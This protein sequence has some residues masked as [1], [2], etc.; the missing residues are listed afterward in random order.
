MSNLPLDSTHE[1]KATDAEPDGQSSQ[2]QQNLTPTR[3]P[4]PVFSYGVSRQKKQPGNLF[5][6]GVQV[7]RGPLPPKSYSPPGPT[8]TSQADTDATKD[9]DA[10]KPTELSTGK[11][12]NHNATTN[13]SSVTTAATAQASTEPESKQLEEVKVPSSPLELVQPAAE[14]VNIN[15]ESSAGIVE[16]SS[17][18]DAVA[19]QEKPNPVFDIG[20]EIVGAESYENEEALAQLLLLEQ[21]RLLDEV[22]KLN[23]TLADD[24][25]SVATIELRVAACDRARGALALRARELVDE[26]AELSVTYSKAVSRLAELLIDRE[27]RL[28]A[29]SAAADS[30]NELREKT[31]ML[32]QH[33]LSA[34]ARM[35]ALQF[36]HSLPSSMLARE[37]ETTR[38]KYESATALLTNWVR[39]ECDRHRQVTELQTK[40]AT[41]EARLHEEIKGTGAVTT[42]EDLTETRQDTPEPSLLREQKDLNADTQM[43]ASSRTSSPELLRTKRLSRDS[44]DSEDQLYYRARLRNQSDSRSRS[45]GRDSLATSEDQSISEAVE[46]L[47]E[48]LR[49]SEGASTNAF[50]TKAE[51]AGQAFVSETLP[52]EGKVVTK[53]MPHELITALEH[54]TH[55]D[56]LGDE[57][58]VEITPEDMVYSKDR[59]SATIIA[60]NSAELVNSIRAQLAEPVSLAQTHSSAI[61]TQQP[62]LSQAHGSPT[63]SETPRSAHELTADLEKLR[64]TLAVVK[65]EHEKA[66]AKVRAEQNKVNSCIITFQALDFYSKSKPLAEKRL[67]ELKTKLL[68]EMKSRLS[69]CIALLEQLS[70]SLAEGFSQ[71]QLLMRCTFKLELLIEVLKQRIGRTESEY[72]EVL[73]L[74]AHTNNLKEE[75]VHWFTTELNAVNARSLKIKQLHAQIAAYATGLS[76]LKKEDDDSARGLMVSPSRVER[77]LKNFSQ[78]ESKTIAAVSTRARQ[79]YKAAEAEALALAE[80]AAKALEAAS[81]TREKAIAARALVTAPSPTDSAAST[82]DFEDIDHGKLAAIRAR[83]LAEAES[84]EAE[85][86]RLQHESDLASEAAAQASLRASS[87]RQAAEEEALAEAAEEAKKEQDATASADAEQISDESSEP[88]HS[89]ED[90]I[91]GIYREHTKKIREKFNRAIRE[92]LHLIQ[93][94]RSG[95]RGTVRRRPISLLG[96]DQ[97]GSTPASPQLGTIELKHSEAFRKFI[98]VLF[99]SSQMN[100]N[101]LLSGLETSP[102]IL[103]TISELQGT[104]SDLPNSLVD[105]ANPVTQLRTSSGGPSKAMPF[106]TARDWLRADPLKTFLPPPPEPS[107]LKPCIGTLHCLFKGVR[108]SGLCSVNSMLF[109]FESHAFFAPVVRHTAPVR[110]P[111]LDEAAKQEPSQLLDSSAASLEPTPQSM[112]FPDFTYKLGFDTKYIIGVEWIELEDHIRLSGATDVLAPGNGQPHSAGFAVGPPAGSSGGFIRVTGGDEQPNPDGNPESMQPSS[113]DSSSPLAPILPSDATALPNLFPTEAKP[114]IDAA[115]AVASQLTSQS[116]VHGHGMTQRARKALLYIHVSPDFVDHYDHG[117]PDTDA[118]EFLSKEDMIATQRANINGPFGTLISSIEN[119]LHLDPQPSTSKDLVSKSSRRLADTIRDLEV[120]C[121]KLDVNALPAR[122]R[123]QSQVNELVVCNQTE[124]SAV[125]RKDFSPTAAANALIQIEK[126]GSAV[127]SEMSGHIND[128]QTRPTSTNSGTSLV[129]TKASA[130]DTRSEANEQSSGEPTL[131]CFFGDKSNVMHIYQA[132]KQAITNRYMAAVTEHDYEEYV[133]LNASIM[134]SAIRAKQ[135]RRAAPSEGTSQPLIG[136]HEFNI[137]D[138]AIPPKSP[139]LPE[140]YAHWA[141]QPVPLSAIAACSLETLE[142]FSLAAFLDDELYAAA[143][144]NLETAQSR[145]GPFFPSVLPTPSSIAHSYVSANDQVLAGLPEP[146]RTKL[147]SSDKSGRQKGQRE[148]GS[149]AYVQGGSF[150]VHYLMANRQEDSDMM[151]PHS[152]VSKSNHS[153]TAEDV[154]P[155]EKWLLF[156]RKGA[157]AAVSSQDDDGPSLSRSHMQQVPQEGPRLAEQPGIS[158]STSADDSEEDDESTEEEAEDNFSRMKRKVGANALLPHDLSR[159]NTTLGGSSH[160][161]DAHGAVSYS[162]VAPLNPAMQRINVVGQ[163]NILTSDQLKELIWHTPR[164]HHIYS[165]SLLYCMSKDGAQISKMYKSALQAPSVT[166]LLVRDSYGSAFGGFIPT[167]WSLVPGPFGSGA[168]FVFAYHSPEACRLAAEAR[169]R[170]EQALVGPIFDNSS[171]PESTDTN[172]SYA[173]DSHHPM[174]ALKTAK[175]TLTV[176]RWV[177]SK[178][179]KDLAFIDRRASGLTFGGGGAGPAFFIDERLSS[180]TSAKSFTYQNKMLS[181]ESPFRIYEIELWG[182]SN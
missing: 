11:G 109:H 6:Q 84:L 18:L 15:A 3:S 72:D 179:S 166:L 53:G 172:Q 123:D 111:P 175:G 118:A 170:R 104:S 97:R 129:P 20:Y 107:G 68:P 45:R 13:P 29:M 79:V 112:A 153:A 137:S 176:Y 142:A 83:Q 148:S 131:L 12:E 101:M 124:Q 30:F 66:V 146:I 16:S 78:A 102:A 35:Q 4:A 19:S 44:A 181:S 43:G 24:Y 169:Q 106:A 99:Q 162:F 178:R 76:L 139:A 54:I 90:D 100:L 69:S 57:S 2:T 34:L 88:A 133:A 62:Q 9:S 80:A 168:G 151:D 122:A 94:K 37:T 82:D 177:E 14:N 173:P 108:L 71:Y 60:R 150:F 167:K 141:K 42:L 116:F 50:L 40:I 157:L 73:Y 64:G 174:T 21:L 147:L 127:L 115:V 52:E 96:P 156:G 23:T 119:E 95:R 17:V 149:E 138:L 113:T 86:A 36:A 126:M 110:L 121:H 51:A 98:H 70:S 114:G 77:L 25:R 5:Y 87:L 81:R 10:S 85:A 61:S 155:S 105:L 92:E 159:D 165:W 1:V 32:R 180:G 59:E 145:R 171:N 8:D 93:G 125:E 140:P 47:T 33:Y 75:L 143:G 120:L 158:G 38:N 154:P 49:Q 132:I 41:L 28:A 39:E 117:I 56:V 130:K 65:R 91:F 58:L 163:S 67:N 26:F 48:V 46:R 144:S 136:S 161:T 128:I 135:Y 31:Q 103:N 134:R 74:A 27:H 63:Q 7:S 164:Q 160:S 22:A 55:S 89:L 182:R 152:H